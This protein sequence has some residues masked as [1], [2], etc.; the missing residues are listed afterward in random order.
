MSRAHTVSE[1]L[2]ELQNGI[3][4][5]Y[6]DFVLD[7]SKVSVV[8]PNAGVPI[9]GILQYYKRE[10]SIEFIEAEE[11]SV[12]SNSKLLNPLD[13]D[14]YYSEYA[15][16]PLNKIWR[17]TNFDQVSCLVNCF[18]EELSRS[19]TF[20]EGVLN[21]LEW[22][23]NEVMDNVLQ[24]SSKSE[25]FIMGQIHRNTKHIAFC[26]F[27]SGQGIYNSLKSSAHR[28]QHPVD[29]LTLCIKEGVTRDKQIGQGN[30]MFGLSQI[31]RNNEGILTI[32]SNKAALY[33]TH[34][35]V[36]T[37]KN[38]PTISFAVGCTSVDF[39]LDYD[40]R[41]SIEDA[42][43]IGGRTGNF[44]NYRVENLENNNGEIEYKLKDRAQG[45]GTRK[46]GL[47]VRNE[48]INLHSESMQPI[49]LDFK[50]INLISSS[51]ADELIG[52]LVL[53]Y[54]FFG[55]N[56]VIRLHN[57]NSVVQTIVQR[58]VSQRMAESLNEP[59]KDSIDGMM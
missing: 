3:S 46:S 4:A 22:S 11:H 39:Q 31:V 55:F 41:V 56:N 30:G 6:Q 20:K 28:P 13:T 51:F 9:S 1:F 10:L 50:G 35:E 59:K 58:S 16:D 5:G 48:I 32:T 27:D 21:G 25:G 29:A 7:F 40:K 36:K 12:I 24:H 8:F 44:V 43:R 53:Y 57:M 37:F 33:Q 47:K 54:G 52:K 14:E 34:K 23:L 49:N 45:Y 38:L 2:I 19:D 18:I 26:I 15:R 42:L 17:F